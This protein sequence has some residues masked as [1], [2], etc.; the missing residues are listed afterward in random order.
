MD[1]RLITSRDNQVL[2]TFRAAA[3]ESRRM[4]EE[5]VVA[6]G[7]RVIEEALRAASEIRVLLV[8]EGFGKT[9]RER[10]LLAGCS[11]RDARI[12]R[13]AGSIFK[14]V[15]GVVAPQGA[16]ALVRV[17]KAKIADALNTDAPF[18]VCA[19]G[20]QDPGNLGSLIRT[21]AAAGCASICTT[22][23]TVSARN[24]KTIR[25]SA[26]TFFR[27][28]V[29]EHVPVGDFLAACAARGVKLF[30][31][32]AGEGRDFS[33]L[34]YSG[35]IAILLGNEGQGL[36]AEDWA[37]IPAVR[38]PMAP[39]VESLNVSAAGAIILFEAARQRRAA[40]NRTDGDPARERT[41]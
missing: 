38:I 15:T 1:F 40:P 16:A 3:A 8:S 37:G 30:R 5:L 7:V 17:P 32:S 19:C 9:D 25:A 41:Q 2:K 22:R 31:T 14:T 13:V 20:I 28:Q 36:R 10:A 4:P 26:G 29:V 39:G 33:E 12:Y 18:V 23:G 11:G 21:A 35:R 24:P 6:E 34:F 27:L